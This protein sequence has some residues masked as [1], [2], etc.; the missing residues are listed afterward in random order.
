MQRKVIYFGY[1]VTY[2]AMYNT[3]NCLLEGVDVYFSCHLII[4]I[5]LVTLEQT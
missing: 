5:I 1:L 3:R 4:I 2:S